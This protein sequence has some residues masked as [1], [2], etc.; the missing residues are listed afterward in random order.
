MR[1]WTFTLLAL[2][3]VPAAAAPEATAPDP[4]TIVNHVLD[5]DPWGLSDGEVSAH[6]TLTDKR[7]STSTIAFDGRSRRYDPPLSKTL[8]RF[9][10]PADLAGA[11]F[12]QVQNRA[13]DDDRYLYL[14]DLKASRR[15][16][17]NLRSSSFMGTDFSFAD[18]DRRDLRD[19]QPSLVGAETVGK[20]ECHHVAVAGNAD[21]PYAKIDLWVRKDD[22]V[23]L[24]QEW[25]DKAGMVAKTLT[26]LEVK[27][28]SGHWFITR[29]LMVNHKESHSTELFLD[30]MVPRS[31]IGDDEFSTRNLEK[32]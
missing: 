12:L 18:I 25:T 3:A 2:L 21:S 13:K 16:A 20:Y 8:V 7:G 9:S 24:K 19:G 22:F 17:G 6:A 27:R 30:K 26:A 31:D 10:A 5:L 29:S 4:R 23:P 15:I 14:P 28:V 1:N 11:G 32:L